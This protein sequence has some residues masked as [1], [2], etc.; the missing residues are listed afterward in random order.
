MNNNDVIVLDGQVKGLNINIK[1]FF[2]FG[3]KRCFDIVCS[4]IGSLFLLPI[5]V[6]IK[7]VYVLSGDFH[8]IFFTHERIGKAGKSFKMY[9]FRT[10]IPNAGEV[11][12]ELLKDPK[13]KEEWQENHKLDNDPRITKLGGI[14][15]KT[16]L[17]EL[18]QLINILKGDMSIIGPRPLVQEEV[19]DYGKN[20]DKL[21]SVRP[22]LTGWWA[23]NG[24]SCT[25][26]KQRRKLELYYVDNCS[27]LLDIKIIFKT[28]IA[29]LKKE[30][31]K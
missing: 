16:S 21:L 15:R 4:F 9:K 2:Y 19:D 24:R 29:V 17:D 18:P 23:C 25:S 22:G 1:K 14:L 7:I 12:E 5:I 3:L 20:K 11:L 26:T 27:M 28:A 10:M 6:I 13:I 31:A 8:S 30:G